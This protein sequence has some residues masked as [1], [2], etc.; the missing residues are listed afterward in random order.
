MSTFRSHAIRNRFRQL[1]TSRDRLSQRDFGLAI[2]L[3]TLSVLFIGGFLAY[4]IVRTNLTTGHQ[5]ATLVIPP[6]LWLSTT[7]LLLGSFSIQRAVFFVRK[8]K[9][10]QFR[11]CLN[12]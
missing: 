1:L 4:V 7:I 11:N 3:F 9:Q 12:L 8:E 5:P 6:A 10:Q 2:F